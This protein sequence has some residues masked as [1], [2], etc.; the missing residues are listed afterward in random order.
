[1]MPTEKRTKKIAL[2]ALFVALHI[3]GGF[4][5]I[6]A[7][8]APITLQLQIALL[9]GIL[10]GGKWGS[11]SVLFYLALGLMGLPVF[12]SG[13][14]IAYVLQPTFG[15]LIGLAVSAFLSGKIVRSGVITYPR[16]A[17]ALSVGVA[18][19]YAIGLFYAACILTLYL[20]QTIYLWEFLLGY[21][22]LTLPKDIILTALTIPLAKRLLPHVL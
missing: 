22:L 14:G 2:C 19:A 9:A 5:R 20:N 7:P 10:L 6:P 1:M 4:V 11:L 15:Y 12:A 18:I 21:L 13:G 8:L 16:I 17:V 3:V